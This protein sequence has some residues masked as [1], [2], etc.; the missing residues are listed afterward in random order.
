MLVSLLAR[1][2][3]SA[4]FA[5]VGAPPRPEP[6]HAARKLAKRPVT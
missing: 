6:P 5:L 2:V 3:S 4:L 1:V